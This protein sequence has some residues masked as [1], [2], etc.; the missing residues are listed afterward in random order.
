M[1][2][3]ELCKLKVKVELEVV[4]QAQNQMIQA[5]G[6][7]SGI[8]N[9]SVKKIDPPSFSGNTREYPNFKEDFETGCTHLWKQRT[10][11]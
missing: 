1:S 11:E 3:L 2:Q 4:K 9:I 10:G 7:S 6:A 5:S 8:S